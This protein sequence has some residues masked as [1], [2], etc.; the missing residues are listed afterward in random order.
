MGA[1]YFFNRHFL[2]NA[3]PCQIDCT[4]LEGGGTVALFSVDA[5]FNY[6]KA[7]FFSNWTSASRILATNSPTEARSIGGAVSA[8]FGTQDGWDRRVEKETMLRALQKKFLR[9]GGQASKLAQTGECPLALASQTDLVWGIGCSV[10]DAALGMLWVGQNLL[11]ELLQEVRHGLRRRR[12][13]K[14]GEAG[15]MCGCSP[16]CSIGERP[17]RGVECEGCKLE[18]GCFSVA[19]NTLTSTKTL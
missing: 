10:L 12:R 15:R 8:D 14:R 19:I 1:V 6:M 2:S 16:L 13:P 11:G 7:Q 5:A 9:G 17:E 4:Y 18:F 3:H